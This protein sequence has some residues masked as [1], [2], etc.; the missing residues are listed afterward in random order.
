MNIDVMLQDSLHVQ[1]HHSNQWVWRRIL[2]HSGNAALRLRCLTANERSFFI[3]SNRIS[4]S[5]SFEV[6]HE[7]VSCI[8][9][10]GWTSDLSEMRSLLTSINFCPLFGNFHDILHF[11]ID[12]KIVFCIMDLHHRALLLSSA[13]LSW[14]LLAWIWR[15]VC[16]LDRKQ[17][18]FHLAE[19]NTRQ[20]DGS[21]QLD[22]MK[23]LLLSFHLTHVVHFVQVLEPADTMAWKQNGGRILGYKMA[24]H[25]LQRGSAG[26]LP[27]E[28]VFETFSFFY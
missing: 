8:C 18:S 26:W 7:L 15:K 23:R 2:S 25:S 24:S 20:T 22:E 19:T 17:K 12:N 11:T 6:L 21:G 28:R 13:W 16:V 14:T 4:D 9:R 1:L 5:Y 3:F 10:C 27:Q